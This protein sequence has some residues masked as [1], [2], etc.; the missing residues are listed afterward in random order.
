[1]KSLEDRFQWILKGSNSQPP[2]I[3]KYLL[4]EMIHWGGNVNGVSGNFDRFS[5]NVCLR[6]VVGELVKNIDE[7]KQAIRIAM[8]ISGLGLH[9]A[10]MLL[11]FLAPEKYAIL[12]NEV[13]DWLRTQSQQEIEPTA[14]HF[15]IHSL[16][17]PIIEDGKFA[18][19]ATGYV[20]YLEILNEIRN[21]LEKYQ[22]EKPECQQHQEGWRVAD[23]GMALLEA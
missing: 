7:P 19:M 5:H 15:Y 11:R 13:Q 4:T 10:S 12:D 21:G 6:D 3:S 16:P 23:V 22:I 2:N 17:L 8:E 20:A 18:S 14:Y 9:Y 1:M